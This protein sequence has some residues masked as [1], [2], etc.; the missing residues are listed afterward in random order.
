[1][2]EKFSGEETSRRLRNEERAEKDSETAA[3]G[4]LNNEVPKPRSNL[5]SF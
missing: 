4:K 1:M 2:S 3:G 5:E